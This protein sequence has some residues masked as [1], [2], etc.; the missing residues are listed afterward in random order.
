MGPL[1]ASRPW[2]TRDVVG[3]Y[4]FLQRLWRNIVDEETGELRRRSTTPA[5]DDTQRLLHRTIDGVRDR[6]GGAALQHRDRQADRAEQPPHQ[7]RR[8][9]R[10]D[11]AEPL[12]L[13]ARPARAARRRGAV[14]QLGHDTITAYEPFPV[15]DPALLVDDTVEYPVQVNGKVRGRDRRSPPTP[16][17]RPSKVP[18]SPT[19][20]SRLPSTEA[21]RKIIVVPGRMV[22][23][24]A[25][26]ALQLGARSARQPSTEHRRP[27]PADLLSLFDPRRMPVFVGTRPEGVP[28]QLGLDDRFIVT[29]DG[30][31][32][33]ERVPARATPALHGTPAR[34]SPTTPA[35]CAR[36]IAIWLCLC[37]L[38][39]FVLLTPGQQPKSDDE[40]DMSGRGQRVKQAV[41]KISHALEGGMGMSRRGEGEKTEERKH[42]APRPEG[43][44]HD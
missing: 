18:R 28:A 2:E 37:S 40:E 3:M 41:D 15:A 17:R 25:M 27:P 32:P 23:I 35:S 8:H 38:Q 7:A 14:G 24:V 6:H 10:R 34:R 5:D 44:A 29:A 13:M 22:N 33:R 39:R 20:R 1:D 11:V 26:T 12:V 30:R 36:T 42:E 19:R 31:R 43:L 4:R 9:A 21:V 16:T